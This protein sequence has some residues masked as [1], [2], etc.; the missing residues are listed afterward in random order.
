MNKIVF[1]GIITFLSLPGGIDAAASASTR[2]KHHQGSFY[3]APV[4]YAALVAGGAAGLVIA[5]KKELNPINNEIKLLKGDNSFEAIVKL[6]RL[7]ERKKKVWKFVLRLVSFCVISGFLFTPLGIKVVIRI[8]A[9]FI[10]CLPYI[11]E[12]LSRRG[13]QTL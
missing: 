9:L 1:F 4:C 3:Y 6:A 8:L 5:L 11:M 12:H 10:D 7:N 13:W 2:S